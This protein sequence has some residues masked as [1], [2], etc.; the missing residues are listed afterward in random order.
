MKNTYNKIFREM[1]EG[2][3]AN[4]SNWNIRLSLDNHK[5][6]V[7]D[8]ITKEHVQ[9]KIISV[10]EF[11]GR[12]F[13]KFEAEKVITRMSEQS[14]S[15]Y[16]GMTNEQILK[17]WSSNA[18]HSADLGTRMHSVI[19][20][21]ISNPTQK[22]EIPSPIP[23]QFGSEVP[24]AL[25]DREG[26][27]IREKH[28]LDLSKYLS[29]NHLIPVAV[30][31]CVFDR[32]LLIAGTIDCIFRNTETNKLLLYDWKRRPTFTIG[33]SDSHYN[34]ALFQLNLYRA[35]LQR[36]EGIMISEM[37]IITIHPSLN[38]ILDNIIEMDDN[39]VEKLIDDRKGELIPI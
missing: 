8:S 11:A 2:R 6:I 7:E 20:K 36:G 15:K 28:L 30:E 13:P 33:G 4:F 29:D 37:H 5:Y 19:E 31:M 1:E 17:Y 24:E 21:Y 9:G 39:L 22:I 18:K 32:E 27:I 16:T 12:Y 14:R 34:H 10:T 38:E 26:I 25:C 3:R 23:S 35:I